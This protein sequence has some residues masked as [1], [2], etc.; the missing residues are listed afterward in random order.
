MNERTEPETIPTYA[1][2]RRALFLRAYDYHNGNIR[3]IA[4]TLQIDKKTAYSWR[5]EFLQNS[6]RSDNRHLHQT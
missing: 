1:E 2:A 5:V 4:E 6:E 3:L